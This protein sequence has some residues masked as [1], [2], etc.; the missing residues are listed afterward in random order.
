VSNETSETKAN[1]NFWKS[2]DN[3][4]AEISGNP[5]LEE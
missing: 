1:K 3:S 5:A 2:Q 4:P